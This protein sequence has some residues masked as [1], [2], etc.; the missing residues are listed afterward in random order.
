MNTKKIICT[1]LVAAVMMSLLSAYG[2]IPSRAS[3][4]VPAV[5]SVTPIS[6]AVSFSDAALTGGV[7]STVCRVD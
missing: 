5:L 3:S 2:S 4:T 7:R 6:T 1:I